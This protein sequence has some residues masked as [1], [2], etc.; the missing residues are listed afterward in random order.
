MYREGVEQTPHFEKFAN[1]P[2][3]TAQYEARGFALRLIG[4]DEQDAKRGT[5]KIEHVGKVDQR[6][7]SCVSPCWIGKSLLY[8]FVSVTRLRP[9]TRAYLNPSTSCPTK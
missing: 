5:G 7:L 1:L 4:G 6:Y 8:L 3:K 9:S 2:C